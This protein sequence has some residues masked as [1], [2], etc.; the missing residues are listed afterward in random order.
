MY[1]QVPAATLHITP[2]P[3]R[4]NLTAIEA[5]CVSQALLQGRQKKSTDLACVGVPER[6]SQQRCHTHHTM[7][8]RRQL[9]MAAVARGVYE[10]LRTTR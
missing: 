4:P 10:A 1:P 2:S 7:L 3:L 8:W 6:H 5:R 9:L